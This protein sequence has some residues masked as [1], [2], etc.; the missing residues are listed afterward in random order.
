M[1]ARRGEKGLKMF[2]GPARDTSR[3]TA[4]DMDKPGVEG[5]DV[6]LQSAARAIGGASRRRCGRR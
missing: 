1:S 6:V 2:G 3:F 5:C 4:D